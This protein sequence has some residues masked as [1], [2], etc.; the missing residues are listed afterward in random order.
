[1]ESY[2]TTQDKLRKALKENFPTGATPS[3]QE[4]LRADIPY[5]DAACEEGF[6]LAG[7][8]KGNLRQACV[9]TEILGYRIPEGAQI[10]MNFHVNHTP[11]PVDESRYAA[12]TKAAVAKHG[13]GLRTSAGENL[14]AFEPARWLVKDEKTGKEVFNS[15]ALPSLAFGGGYRGCAGK[16]S[17][18]ASTPFLLKHTRSLIIAVDRHRPQASNHGV[19][20][21][22]H[23]AYL[24]LG[25]S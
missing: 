13:D 1:M 11:A 2:P 24:E 21:R 12:G 15:H 19:S 20:Y 4:I 18:P 8:A 25:V 17:S 16:S 14:G 10:L 5:L 9:D 6:R 22:C 3:V 23:V 7:V